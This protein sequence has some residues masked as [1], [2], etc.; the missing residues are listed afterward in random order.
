VSAE[1]V[2]VWTETFSDGRLDPRR[3]VVTSAGDFRARYVDVEEMQ[4]GAAGSR[5]RLAADTVATRDDTVKSLG[6]RSVPLIQLT[7]EVRVGVELDWNK[8]RNGSYLTVSV[9]LSRYATVTNPFHERD[10]VKVEYVGVP[11]GQ[12]ARMVVVVCRQGQER[13][14]Y[15]EG[16]PERNR[17]GRPIQRQRIVLVFRDRTLQ[18]LENDERVYESQEPVLD[19]DAAYLY[20]Q[21]STHSNY[22]LRTVYFD[23]VR[24]EEE[25]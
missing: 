20:L 15:N 19:A 3:W 1:R 6:V 25:R 12:N 14:V 8:Q 13:T 11:P 23:D 4:P 16:W 5:L 2:T 10:W 21:M 18:I 24:V 7:G 22:P 9:G 17:A